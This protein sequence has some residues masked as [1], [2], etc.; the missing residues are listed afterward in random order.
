L[1]NVCI[2]CMECNCVKF[3]KTLK[4]WNRWLEHPALL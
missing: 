4:N 2:S 1:G 3:T